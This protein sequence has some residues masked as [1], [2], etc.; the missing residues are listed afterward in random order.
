[1]HGNQEMGLLPW[2][3]RDSAILLQGRGRLPQGRKDRGRKEIVSA[4]RQVGG[5]DEPERSQRA[6]F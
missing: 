5:N 1:M 6:Y 2:E 3:L 4:A